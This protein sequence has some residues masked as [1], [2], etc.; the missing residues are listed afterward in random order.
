M[1]LYEA[2]EIKFEELTYFEKIACECWSGDNFYF[3]ADLDQSYDC[4][5]GLK[6]KTSTKHGS[7]QLQSD[8][9]EIIKD[10][11]YKHNSRAFNNWCKSSGISNSKTVNN[12]GVGNI[13]INS[14]CHHGC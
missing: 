13:Y 1:K 10:Q 8:L 4:G 6:L 3:D 11:F 9:K 14:Q 12:T 5:E 7:C 2:P